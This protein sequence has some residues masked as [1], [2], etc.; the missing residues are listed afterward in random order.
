MIRPLK[1]EDRDTYLAMA[2]DFYDSP[3][4]DHPVPTAFLERTFEELMAGTPYAEAFVFEEAEG[5]A[6]YAL[7]A[8]TWSQE[9]GGLTVWLEEL[10]VVPEW[11][12]RGLGRQ[13][14]AWLKAQPMP[15]RYRLETEPENERAKA[16]Y[17]R[18]GFRPLHYESFILGD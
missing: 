18:E 11:Q 9:A 14:F 12:N 4:V 17:L 6:G 7:L 16:L 5:L 1:P 15:A 8:K 10:Y 2:R 3:A 13:F